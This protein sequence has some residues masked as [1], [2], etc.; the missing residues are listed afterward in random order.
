MSHITFSEAY[1]LM[2]K[3]EERDYQTR[4]KRAEKLSYISSQEELEAIMHK[5]KTVLEDNSLTAL[6][7]IKAL[8]STITES[9]TYQVGIW[10]DQHNLNILH[11]AIINNKPE[12]INYLLADTSFFPKSHMPF[13]NPY[14]HLAALLGHKECLR[15][16]LQYRPGDFFKITQSSQ[17]LKLPEEY[18]KRLKIKESVKNNF[19]DKIKS[20]SESNEETKLARNDVETLMA[21]IEEEKHDKKYKHSLTKK[22]RAVREKKTP[23]IDTPS[24]SAPISK[25]RK[26]ITKSIPKTGER[27]LSTA[28]IAPANQ[29]ESKSM[30]QIERIQSQP[31]LKLESRT[32]TAL[33]LKDSTKVNSHLITIY[34]NLFT[35]DGPGILNGAGMPATVNFVDTPKAMRAQDFNS[36][37][38]FRNN[39]FSEQKTVESAYRHKWDS[40]STKK[41]S[42]DHMRSSKKL[43]FTKPS[44]SNLGEPS[45]AWVKNERI[46]IGVRGKKKYKEFRIKIDHREVKEKDDAYRSMNK[47]PLTIAA[48]RGHLECVQ[49][50]LDQVILKSNPMIATKEPLTLAT[51]ARSPEAIILLVQ[52]KMSRWDYQSAVLVAIRELYPDCLTALLT[53]SGKERATLFDGVNLFHVLYSQSLL[54]NYRY[55]LMP[56]MTRVLLSCKENVNAHNIPRTF[57][58]YTLISCAFNISQMKQIYYYLECLTILLEAK[59][60][61]HYSEERAEKDFAKNS[62]LSFTRKSFS[63]AITCILESA[64]GSLD[65]FEKPYF[66]KMFVKKF[67]TTIETF[68]KTKRMILYDVLFDYVKYSNIFGLDKS[69]IKSLMRYGANPDSKRAGKYAVNAYFDIIL[70]YLTKFEV[71][72]SYDHYQKELVDVMY[73]CRYMS[74]KCLNEALKVFLEE[75]LL[76]SPIQALPVCRYFSYLINEMV[77]SP[78]SL[79]EMTSQQIWLCVGRNK[80]RAKSLSLS[81]EL[82]TIIIP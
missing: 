61:P 48:E 35:E 28:L 41:D 4:T 78:R 29:D 54:S 9:F 77:R 5:V 43:S 73:I 57:P 52:K 58:M 63:S 46:D 68:D 80:I 21:M 62:G 55:E 14:G 47:T 26:S 32:H 81:D 37:S 8:L 36:Q 79:L 31:K 64:K 45:K 72:N 25:Y 59:A 70:P 13:Q 3:K 82:L 67:I 22:F 76:V 40:P 10:R 38:M 18:Y 16:I 74:P 17:F 56:E 49:F 75:H 15:V 24:S 50:L 34:R 51:K 11:Y 27:K 19:L 12:I 60:N 69:I 20:Y 66:S 1:N 44:N 42:M 71:I 6:K 23:I 39:T 65:Y 53:I 2:K 30:F 33:E 7:S